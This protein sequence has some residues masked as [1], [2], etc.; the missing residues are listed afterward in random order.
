MIPNV[1]VL[2]TSKGGAGK[3]TLARS[4]G[5]YWLNVGFKVAIIDADPQG[6]IINRHDPEGELKK[7]KVISDPEESVYYTI[8]DTKKIYKPTIVDTGGFRNKTSIKAIINS[9]LVLIPL[10]PS[11][12]DMVAAIETYQLINEL[13]ETPERKGVPIK[14]KMIL[15]MSQQGTVISRHI[16]RELEEVGMPVLKSEMYQR[17]I[18]PES[19]IK[20]LAPSITEPE[21]AAARDVSLIANEISTI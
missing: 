1:I 14:V 7:L 12:D 10:K 5:A 4:L 19:A 8:N 11:A 16:R 3:S 13:N 18:Y 9:D 17:V 15:T 6:S 2:A 21:G 20:G